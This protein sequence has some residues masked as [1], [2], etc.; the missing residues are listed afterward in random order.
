M[1]RCYKIT[2]LVEERNNRITNLLL[3]NNNAYIVK[4]LNRGREE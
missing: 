3:A 4:F 2:G 1:Q